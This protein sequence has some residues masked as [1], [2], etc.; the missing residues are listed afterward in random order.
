M[1]CTIIY[2][3]TTV[4]QF[5]STELIAAISAIAT[6]CAVIVSLFLAF[7]SR[8][9]KYKIKVNNKMVGLRISN[10]G[11]A[12]IFINAFGIYT[13]GKY[14]LNPTERFVKVLPISKKISELHSTFYE[15]SLG[16]ALIEPGDV[17]EVGLVSFDYS[18]I[19]NK[20]YLF[21]LVNGKIKKYKIDAQGINAKTRTNMS[22][23]ISISKAELSDYGF[24][25]RNKE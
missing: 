18:L 17:V 4:W 21:L 22:D 16:Q 12:K 6:L 23:Y 14:Y 8:T 5:G 11:D 13:N 9:V 2:L 25:L 15:W 7:K 1:F 20:T 24:Y 19:K 10:T 3:I